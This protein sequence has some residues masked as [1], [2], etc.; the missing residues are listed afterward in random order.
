MQKI[1]PNVHRVATLSEREIS[2]SS[3][4]DMIHDYSDFT[5]RAIKE[6]NEI[7]NCDNINQ[8][9]KSSFWIFDKID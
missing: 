2:F 3:A 5:W 9:C 4:I 7:N 8:Q 6:S 1:S